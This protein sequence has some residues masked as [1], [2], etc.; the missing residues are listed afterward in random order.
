MDYYNKH[1]EFLPEA[2]ALADWT[3]MAKKDVRIHFKTEI[4][5]N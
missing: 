5:L 2:M 3:E 1:E 4:V